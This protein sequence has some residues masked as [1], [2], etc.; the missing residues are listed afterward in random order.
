MEGVTA[1]LTFMM[2][3]SGMRPG[4]VNGLEPRLFRKI[5]CSARSA[6]GKLHFRISFSCGVRP[7]E[8]AVQ[9]KEQRVF[10]TLFHLADFAAAGVEIAVA[11]LIAMQGEV[12]PKA[13]IE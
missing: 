1:Q 7:D 8:T 4:A 6:G 12:T 11:A 5:V 13:S 9:Q 3:A 10:F 2:P